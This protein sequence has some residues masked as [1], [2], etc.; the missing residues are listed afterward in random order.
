MIDA[1]LTLKR[2]HDVPSLPVHDSLIVPQVDHEL[3]RD[4]LSRTYKSRFGIIPILS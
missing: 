1:I 3:V 2:K 4:V